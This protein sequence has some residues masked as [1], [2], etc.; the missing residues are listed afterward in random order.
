MGVGAGGERGEGG[1]AHRRTC[2]SARGC[3]SWS[4][5]VPEASRSE[6]IMPAGDVPVRLA[7]ADGERPH[8]RRDDAPGE[9]HGDEVARLEV[10][11]AAHDTL[12][13]AGAVG[14]ANIDRTT[15]R[16]SG[17]VILRA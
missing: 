9:D 16:V 8:R 2:G 5:P 3:P 7:G 17:G 14:I 15:G 6:Q 4:S 11:G 13:L 1:L 12:R 10:V